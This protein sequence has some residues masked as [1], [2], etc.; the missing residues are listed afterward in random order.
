M[1][2][3]LFQPVL[4]SCFVTGTG[5]DVG[6]TVVAAALADRLQADYWKPVQSGLADL[7]E[8]DSG[9][10]ARLGGLAAERIVPPLYGLQAPLSPDQAAAL[11]GVRIDMAAF[12][13]PDGNRPSGGNRPLVVEGAGG[14]LVPLTHRHMMVHLMAR[15]LLPTVVVANS[16]LGTINHTLLTLDALRSRNLPIAGVILNGPPQPENA[17]AIERFGATPIL[18]LLPPLLP[19]SCET[20]RATAATWDLSPLTTPPPPPAEGAPDAWELY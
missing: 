1:R 13:L 7:P 18:G 6:K 9:T 10:V 11:E 2:D 19:L 14:V 15:L 4:G 8:G 3:S 17:R 12:G 16:G 5:T 20:L